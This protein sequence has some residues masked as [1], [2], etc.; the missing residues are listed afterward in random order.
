MFALRQNRPNPF[1]SSTRIGFTM[2][3]RSRV[4][5]EVFTV[6]GNRVATLS[7]GELE[8]GWHEVSWDGRTSSRGKAAPG[9]YLYRLTVNGASAARKMVVLE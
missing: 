4:S 7:D 5:L 9:V 6:A 2:A 1:G 8:A 3:R